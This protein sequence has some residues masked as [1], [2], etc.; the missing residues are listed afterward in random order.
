MKPEPKKEQEPS[1]EDLKRTA[2]GKIPGLEGELSRDDLTKVNG[3]VVNK[4]KA[5]L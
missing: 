2:D 3:G 5:P 4:L 1:E